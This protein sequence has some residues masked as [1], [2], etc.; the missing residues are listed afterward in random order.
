MQVIV[1]SRHPDGSELREQAV[2]RVRSAMRRLSALVPRARIQ[3]SDI[4]RP[5]GG[6]DKRRQLAKGLIT[7][8]NPTIFN[9]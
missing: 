7:Q 1:E 4:N 6:V 2:A 3:L 8:P 9:I 5:R